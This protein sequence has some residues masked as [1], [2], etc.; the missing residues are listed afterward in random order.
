MLGSWVRVRL[1]AHFTLGGIAAP[2]DR[3]APFTPTLSASTE[4][5]IAASDTERVELLPIHARQ[6][7]AI[8]VVH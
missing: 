8:S 3:V 4:W 2:V 5:V 6:R 1:S 7:E